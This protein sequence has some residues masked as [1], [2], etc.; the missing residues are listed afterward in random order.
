MAYEINP[1]ECQGC[2]K[3]MENCPVGAIS[4]PNYTCEIDAS[5]C[6]GCGTCQS[7]CPAGAIHG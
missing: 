5:K 7:Y 3:C 6:I 1:Q 4:K 2:G